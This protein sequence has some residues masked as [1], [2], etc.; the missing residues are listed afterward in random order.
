VA[1]ATDHGR[2]HETG[3]EA[4]NEELDP[5]TPPYG[6]LLVNKMGAAKM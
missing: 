3:R 5:S 4:K 6:S 2:K 1:V